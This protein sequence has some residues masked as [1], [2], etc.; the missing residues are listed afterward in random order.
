MLIGP[1]RRPLPARSAPLL[2]EPRNQ[3]VLGLDGWWEEPHY[4]LC[5]IANL[6]GE[7]ILATLVQRDPEKFR[8]V[9]AAIDRGKE[10]MPE[11]MTAFEWQTS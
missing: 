6:R 4:K 7:F 2:H 5:Y 10:P 8:T 9:I 3:L 11:N 1:P